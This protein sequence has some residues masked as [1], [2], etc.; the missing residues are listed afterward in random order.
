[1]PELQKDVAEPTPL[2][3]SKTGTNKNKNAGNGKGT[4]HRSF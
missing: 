4:F 3:G 1:M 2:Y